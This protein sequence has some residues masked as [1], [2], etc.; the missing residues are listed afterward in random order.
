MRYKKIEFLNDRNEFISRDELN[1]KLLV[2]CEYPLLNFAFVIANVLAENSVSS[3]I[4]PFGKKITDVLREISELADIK[5]EII[6][7]VEKYFLTSYPPDC[8]RFLS[9]LDPIKIKKFYI[10]EFRLK[11]LFN[12]IDEAIK[13]LEEMINLSIVHQVIPNAVVAQAIKVRARAYWPFYKKHRRPFSVA[14]QV[15]SLW[16]LVLRHKNAIHWQNI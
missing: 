8:V 1:E 15:S 13:R 9:T 14:T 12:Y 11:S 3:P 4:Y 6:K 2:F 10:S 7:L 5:A 16:S